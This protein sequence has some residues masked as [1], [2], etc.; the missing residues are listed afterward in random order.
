MEMQILNFSLCIIEQLIFLI[1][2]NTTFQKRFRTYI[3]TAAAVVIMSIISYFCGD[4]DLILKTVICISSLTICCH[5]FYTDKIYVHTAIVITILYIIL[6]VDIIFGNLFALIF[7]AQFLDV[8]YSNF[9]YRLVVC[10]IIKTV[11]VMLVYM[12][13]KF[14]SESGLD[15]KKHL[16]ILYNIVMTVFMIISVSFVYFYTSTPNNKDTSFFF[17]IMSI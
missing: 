11:D 10:L 12:L 6:I 4:M 5:I 14:F 7:S 16:W 17:L 2:F 9:S 8:F 3:P 13:Y 1:F 15:M